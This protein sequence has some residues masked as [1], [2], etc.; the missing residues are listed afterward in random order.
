MY[1]KRFHNCVIILIRK[2]IH[3]NHESKKKFLLKNN[4]FFCNACTKVSENIIKYDNIYL[5]LCEE[6]NMMKTTL[7]ILLLLTTGIVDNDC[8]SEAGT[9]SAVNEDVQKENI[10]DYEIEEYILTNDGNED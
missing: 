10:G 7:M 3:I 5:H 2:I 4:I 1:L 9:F 6:E 8:L